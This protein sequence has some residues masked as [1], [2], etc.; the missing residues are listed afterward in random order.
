[1]DYNRGSKYFDFES[2]EHPRLRVTQRCRIWSGFGVVTNI[3]PVRCVTNRPEKVVGPSR[4]VGVGIP[5]KAVVVP[6]TVVRDGFVV[7]VVFLR[8]AVI[9][10]VIMIPR[11][12]QVQ[13]PVAIHAG[14]AVVL[15]PQRHT[16]RLALGEYTLNCARI[17]AVSRTRRIRHPVQ[18]NLHTRGNSS[19]I[20]YNQLRSLICGTPFP[21]P[22]A[23]YSV[24]SIWV[25]PKNQ[26]KIST[27]TI[28]PILYNRN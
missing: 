16:Y 26:S 6:A 27:W 25:M 3:V 1:M 9:T 12:R 28:D 24:I 17:T 15:R 8:V 14:R 22:E 20:G 11:R 5:V 21:R 19:L 10:H 7:C 4:I 18:F 13:H 2:V 23:C